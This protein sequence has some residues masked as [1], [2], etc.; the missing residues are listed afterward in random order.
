[1]ARGNR[2]FKVVSGGTVSVVANTPKSVAAIIAPSGG[3]FKV[4]KFGLYVADVVLASEKLWTVELCVSTQAGAGTS[5]AV[6]PTKTS[7][8]GAVLATAAKN[9]TAEPTVL[10]PIEDWPLDPNKGWTGDV[11]PQSD[12][13]ECPAGGA[14]VWRVTSPAGAATGALRWM[15]TAE[16]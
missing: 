10:T 9:Y 4:V 1:M 2:Q 11:V 13:A 14:L 3:S 16:E 8:G 15:V 5:T 6:T 12:E 7:G